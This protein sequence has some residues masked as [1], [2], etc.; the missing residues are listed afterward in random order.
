MK[1]M[2]FVVFYVLLLFL[3]LKGQ[4]YKK[5]NIF[6][7]SEVVSYLSICTL[8]SLFLLVI[9]SLIYLTPNGPM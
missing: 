8:F 6:F 5:K 3:C 7:L 4:F 9:L 2:F 1:K